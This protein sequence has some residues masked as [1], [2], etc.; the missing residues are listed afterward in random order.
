M[1]AA[2]GSRLPSNRQSACAVWYVPS[3]PGT[4]C[5]PHERRWM[6]CDGANA[7]GCVPGMPWVHR[8]GADDSAPSVCRGVVF[9]RRCVQRRRRSGRAEKASRGAVAVAGVLWVHRHNRMALSASCGHWRRIRCRF[10]ES[11]PRKVGGRPDQRVL[12]STLIRTVLNTPL[13]E[14]HR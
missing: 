5:K 6:T 10:S 1:A 12:G 13:Q 2:G 9:W 4:G 7:P 8:A 3:I 11:P 14:V